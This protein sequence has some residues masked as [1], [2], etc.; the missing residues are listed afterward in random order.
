MDSYSGGAK[1][2]VLPTRLVEIAPGKRLRPCHALQLLPGVDAT[3]S[4]QSCSCAQRPQGTTRRTQRGGARV[5]TNAYAR[6]DDPDLQVKAKARP[7]VGVRVPPS[8]PEEDRAPPTGREMAAW[9]SIL[10]SRRFPDAF[11]GSAKLRGAHAG[12]A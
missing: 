6:R 4:G 8:V 10:A 9:G 1:V 7:K 5:T 3:V 2:F 12:Y 11:L